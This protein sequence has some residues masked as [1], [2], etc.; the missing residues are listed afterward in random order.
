MISHKKQE[1]L[2]G[3]YKHVA[4]LKDAKKYSFAEIAE[5]LRRTKGWAHW[6]YRKA[7]NSPK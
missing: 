7:K 1:E 6:A 2:K 5:E 4:H 3:Q